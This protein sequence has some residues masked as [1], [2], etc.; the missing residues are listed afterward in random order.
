[1]LQHP[2]RCED[3]TIS[4]LIEWGSPVASSVQRKE[5]GFS[6]STHRS[7][8]SSS[9]IPTGLSWET[10]TI[11]N[12][13]AANGAAGYDVMESWLE[14]LVQQWVQEAESLLARCNQRIV[15]QS[16]DTRSISNSQAS[17]IEVLDCVIP[18]DQ[19]VKSI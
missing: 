18:E 16:D 15:D 13:S 4:A 3:F 10:Q 9:N 8:E 1:M 2:L 17:R 19:V 14:A 12:L 5:I 7:T 11:A 6:K